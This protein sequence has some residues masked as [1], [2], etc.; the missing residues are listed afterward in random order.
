[1]HL[2]WRLLRA[3][4]ISLVLA[5]AGCSNGAPQPDDSAANQPC[6]ALARQGI[7]MHLDA[8]MSMAAA[9]SL[10]VRLSSRDASVFILTQDFNPNRLT[11]DVRDG[12]ITRA[13]CR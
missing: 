3:I 11:V 4:P 2:N 13:V 9:R 7:G 6:E 8:F 10:P 12:H 1:M 5:S